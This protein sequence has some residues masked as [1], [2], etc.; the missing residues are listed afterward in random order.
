MFLVKA[1]TEYGKA[2]CNLNILKHI[3][4]KNLNRREESTLPYWQRQAN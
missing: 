3:A 4:S 2:D 1:K